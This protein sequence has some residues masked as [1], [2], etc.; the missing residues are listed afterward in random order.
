MSTITLSRKQEICDAASR[1]F[2]RKG[3]IAVTMRDLAAEVGVKAPSLYNHI[4]SKQEILQDIIIT[5]AEEYTQEMERIMGED[6]TVSEKLRA[7]FAHHFEMAS[8]HPYGM[9][10]LNNDWMHLESSKEYYLKLRTNF[11]QHF[12][13]IIRQGKAEGVLKD[14]DEEII[15][16][17]TFMTLRN[18]YL[19]IPKKG[20]SNLKKIAADLTAVIL[21][22]IEK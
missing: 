5:L 3:Y 10:S 9:A 14:V 19:W 16:F 15:L 7:V 17:S 18:L 4:S 13:T 6:Y 20:N 8:K 2:K 22:G 12:R 11:E 1:L 21:T